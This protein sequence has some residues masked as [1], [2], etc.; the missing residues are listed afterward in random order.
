MTTLELIT[1]CWILPSL[2]TF[3][4]LSHIEELSIEDWSY[5]TWI[6]H[7]LASLGW[8]AGFV[9]VSVAAVIPFLLKERTITI[10][11]R[12]G[13]V[14]VVTSVFTS[15]FIGQSLWLYFN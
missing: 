4:A 13:F 9:Y 14:L 8:P 2:C 12:L 1:V 7:I 10:D 6:P 3:L 11:K 5:Q 15:L